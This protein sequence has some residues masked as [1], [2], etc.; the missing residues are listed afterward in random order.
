M[1][2]ILVVTLVALALLLFIPAK[3]ASACSGCGCPAYY[4]VQRG[5]TLYSIGRRYGVSVWQLTSWNHIPNANCI[6]AGQVLVVYGGCSGGPP[7]GP[8]PGGHPGG[9]GVYVVH[10]GDTLSRIAYRYGTSVW[11]IA[12]AN[13]IRNINYI[14]VGQRLFIP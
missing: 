3:E 12:N 5:D 9:H 10:C 2:N 14:Y 1:K 8:P 4:R 6:Y 13:G 7:G 11:A